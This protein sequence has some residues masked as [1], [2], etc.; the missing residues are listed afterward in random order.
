MNPR[1]IPVALIFVA[2]VAGACSSNSSSTTSTTT[3][4][5]TTVA[6]SSTTTTV[7][8]LAG[9]T[10]KSLATTVG[11][12][13]GAAGHNYIPIVFQNIGSTPCTLGGFPGVALT[14]SA[15]Q[16][17]IQAVRTSAVPKTIT[18]AAQGFGSALLT[19]TDVPSGNETTCPT[20]AGALV[21]PPNDTSSQAL[22]VQVPGCSTPTIGVVVPG[23]AGQ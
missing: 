16:Q 23:S 22:T 13:Q 3:S 15:G 20:Y 18:L 11:Q 19:A 12:A 17:V 1:L 4:P 21:T 10:T 14:N 6:P 2:L 5:S 7:A 8:K 9:C